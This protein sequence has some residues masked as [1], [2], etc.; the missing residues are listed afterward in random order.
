MVTWCETKK[1]PRV[2]PLL[3]QTDLWKEMAEN[4]LKNPVIIKFDNNDI[5]SKPGKEG[6]DAYEGEI[7]VEKSKWRLSK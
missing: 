6:N 5:F 2:L 1:P 7:A 4:P 3:K